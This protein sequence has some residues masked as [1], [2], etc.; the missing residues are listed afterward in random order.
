MGPFYNTVRRIIEDNLQEVLRKKVK[1]HMFSK[2]MMTQRVEKGTRLLRLIWRNKWKY[3]VSID[4]AWVYL[5]HVNGRSR[6]GEPSK[7]SQI[8]STE[9][10]EWSHVCRW[11]QWPWPHSH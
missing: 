5:K 10:S 3:V 2:K 1:T 7:L 8:L 4:E 9:A 6:K 11:N